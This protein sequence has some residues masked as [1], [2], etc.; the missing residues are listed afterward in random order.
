MIDDQSLLAGLQAIPGWQTYFG[1]PTG[2]YLGI[3]AASIFLPALI[4]AF[5]ADYLC[6]K[7]GRKKIIYVGSLLIVIGGI[8]NALSQ[9]G[10]QFMGGE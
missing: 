10:G 5:V 1:R 3:I 8:F 4:V 6:T 7:F 9:S 2:T